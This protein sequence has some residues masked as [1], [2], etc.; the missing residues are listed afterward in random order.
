M[1]KYC[2]R[3]YIYENIDQKKERRDREAYHDIKMDN[4]FLASFR[5]KKSRG[6]GSLLQ[7]KENFGY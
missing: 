4:Y 1:C 3:Y 2:S 6:S 7:N 5:I